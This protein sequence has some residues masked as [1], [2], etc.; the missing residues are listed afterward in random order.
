[1]SSQLKESIT[2]SIPSWAEVIE[3]LIEF[4]ILHQLKP[5]LARTDF[6]NLPKSATKPMVGFL[7]SFALGIGL[8]VWSIPLYMIFIHLLLSG[9][10]VEAIPNHYENLSYAIRAGSWFVVPALLAK[11]RMPQLEHWADSVW[12]VSSQKDIDFYNHRLSTLKVGVVFSFA[13]SAIPLMFV[14]FYG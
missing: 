3:L 8:V 12:G 7:A 14:G 11:L 9:W 2:E 13:F 4:L 6:T 5:A 10:D 1:M